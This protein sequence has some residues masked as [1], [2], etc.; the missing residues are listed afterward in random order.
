M[1]SRRGLR[2]AERRGEQRRREQEESQARQEYQR[3]GSGAGGSVSTPAPLL[4]RADD[5][6]LLT[7]P[8]TTPRAAW[9]AWLSPV[10]A[11]NDSCYFTGT[12]RDDYGFDNGLMLPRNVFKDFARYMASW[13]F[14]G[15][16]IVGVE[17]HQYRDILHLHGILEGPFTTEQRHWIKDYWEAQ[18]G[19]ARALPVLDGCAS[20]VTKY[21]LKGDTDNFEWR[22]S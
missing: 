12:Y 11:G 2:N 8:G 6:C 19:Y 14:S 9:V 10:F 17:Q 5:A 20:Y 1:S 3:L 13:G 15:R 7:S 18:R 21:A 16:Y 22:L 4:V